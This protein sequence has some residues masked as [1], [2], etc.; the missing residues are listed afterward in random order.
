MIQENE[1]HKCKRFM[2]GLNVKIK[3]HLAWASQNNFGELV[4]AALK[5][6]RTVSVL[7][8]GRPDSKRGAPST[9]QPGTSQFSIKKGTKWT[10]GRGSGRGVASSQR[11]VRSSAATGGGR[12]SGSSFPLCSTCQRRH[13]GECRMNI[14]GCFNCGQEGHF[15]R[16][17]PQ[18]V[19]AETSEV[20]TVASTPGTSGPSQAGRGGSGRG[21]SSATGR[22]R[23]RGAGGRGS[24][25]IGQ[26]QSGIRTQ[27]Q[28]FSVTQQEA[29]ASPYVITGMISVYDHDAYALVDPGATHSFI[30]V[31]FTERHQIESQ[32]IDG[33]MV[34][35][36][37]N[38][39]T[40]ISGRIVPGS[41]LVI[42]NK[43]FPA[44]LIVLGIHDFDIILG[45]DWLSKHRATLDCYKKEVRLVRPEEPGVIFRGIRREI[46]PSLI[47]AMTASKM[48][49]KGCQGYLAFIVDMRQEGT[50]LEDIPIVKEFPDVFPDDISGLPPDREVEFTID[51]IPETE[52]IS[53][54][55][56]K[57][58]PAE[59]RKLKAQL[60]DLLSKGF[61][62]PSISPW[63]APVLFVKKKDGSLRL[64]IDYRQLNRVTI[65]NQYPLPRIDELFDQLQRSRVYSK[66]DLRSGYHQLRVQESDVPKT[67]FRTRYGHYEFLVMPFG[68][69][70]APAAFMDLMNRVFQPYL[71][72]FVIIFIDDI[73]VYSG[74]SEEHSEHLRIV[75]QTLRERQLYA[76]LSKC[77][78]WLDRVAFLGH[79]ISAE[80]VSVDPQ[81]IEAVVNWKPPKNVSEV[82]SFLGLAGY[83][84]KFVEGFSKIAA[85]LTKLTR[86][87][88]KYDLVDAC[89]QS[90]EDLKSRL[91]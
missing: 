26:I 34:V 23:G 51:L 75:L 35:S 62:R 47:N 1:E 49:R 56:Y 6:E 59:L 42:Q 68:L 36:V 9:S 33:R 10:S 25:P 48:L 37:P 60:E 21:G 90:F 73:L 79:V 44:D 82:R 55:P 4:E 80:G 84:R 83:Y 66:I 15:I 81:K 88:V 71:D 18:L 39:D 57:M 45:M 52:P 77:Q 17:C 46:A 5:V 65:R 91:T 74:S 30:S 78:F 53:I 14:T 22:G 58:A 3:V 63:G 87:D 19:A 2:A 32:P 85:P 54:P 70:N 16:D 28:V 40:M 20:G 27:A 13:L 67:A 7:T 64:C 86:K 69:T 72:R 61:I 12:S 43:D 50:R 8:Q 29:D 24:T 38:G 76:K 11:S 89:Q 41:R 31:P